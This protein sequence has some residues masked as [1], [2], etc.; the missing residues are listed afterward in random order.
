MSQLDTTLPL[1]PLGEVTKTQSVQ[2]F[3]G[4]VSAGSIPGLPSIDAANYATYRAI[5]RDPTVALARAV[6]MGP[7]LTSTW[8]YEAA[9]DTVPSEWVDFI[10]SQIDPL[11]DYILRTAIGFGAI[12]YGWC[13]WEKIFELRDGMVQLCGLKQLLHDLTE[14]DVDKA[15]GKFAGFSQKRDKVEL[16]VEKCLLYTGDRE[17]DNFYGRPR[18]ENVR[19]IWAWWRSANDGAARYDNKIAG[20]FP[21]ISY[22]PGECTNA[23]GMKISNS[24]AAE[25]LAQALA[26]GKPIIHPKVASGTADDAVLNDP[27]SQAWTVELLEDKGSRQPGFIERLRYLDSLKM[28]A[29]LRPERSAIEGQ[30]GTNAEAATHND[31]GLADGELMQQDVVRMVNWH[32][33]DQLLVLN[34]G[35]DA[36]GAIVVTP[37]P[38]DDDTRA[39][40]RAIVQALIASPVA[41]EEFLQRVSIDKLLEK[42]GLPE[43]TEEERG[44]MGMNAPAESNDDANQKLGDGGFDPK[45]PADSMLRALYKNGQDTSGNS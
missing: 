8:S 28:R 24:K 2:S 10:K 19:E 39:F 27:N 36:R 13:G 34:F 17:G 4:S 14:I 9:D 5:R 29:L 25:A 38:L 31:V 45:N 41:L 3:A 42:V 43:I 12:D 32:I 15:T 33:V 16:P 37:T 11:R 30:N 20:V 22:P 35:E 1:P 40:Y 23:A 26:A 44:E 21:R 6:V 7:I 18:L